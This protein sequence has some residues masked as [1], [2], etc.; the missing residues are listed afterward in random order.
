M[1]THEKNKMMMFNATGAV[2]DRYEEVVNA[3]PPLAEARAR[4]NGSVAD[5][6]Q[7]NSKYLGVIEGAVAA[8][9]NSLDDLVERVFRLGNAVFSIGRK[10]GNEQY[11]SAGN[12]SIADLNHMRETDVELHCS[13]IAGIAKECADELSIFGVTAEEIEAFNKALETY[14][15][16]VDSKEVKTAESRAARKSLYECFDKADDILANDID[17]LMELVKISNPDFYNQYRAA[18]SIRD[19]GGRLS[20]NGKPIETHEAVPLAMA[21]AA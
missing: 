15:K 4:F 5:I 14:R 16:M 19:L 1:N 13:K 9:N 11:K 6:S 10:T 17:T 21:K 18:R 20:K 3:M 2:L 12:V 8:K 7:R